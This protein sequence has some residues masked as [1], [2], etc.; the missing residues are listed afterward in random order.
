MNQLVLSIELVSN[1]EKEITV[2]MKAIDIEEEKPK[3]QEEEEEDDIEL[4]G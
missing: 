4:E 2:R 1:T 3:V